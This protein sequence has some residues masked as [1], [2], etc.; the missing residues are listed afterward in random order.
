MT[1]AVPTAA[2]SERDRAARL[3][4]DRSVLV[5]VD[6]QQRL[7]PHVLNH[8]AVIARIEA[9]LEASRLFGIPR[10]A[11]EHAATRIG[12]LIERMRRALAPGEIFAKTRFSAADHPEF[13]DRLRATRRPQ[14]VV[15]G[16]EA[17]VCVLQTALGLAAA[18]FEPFVVVDAVGSRAERRTE[19]RLALERMRDAGCP[20]LGTETLLFEWSRDAD[21]A[22]FREILALVKALPG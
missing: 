20:L 7:A 19:R 15:S 17:H 11:T 22:C 6:V 8:E 3:D 5:V 14:I 16:M 21:D 9:L 4:R 1:V 13:I 2:A 18:G 12:P 10:L